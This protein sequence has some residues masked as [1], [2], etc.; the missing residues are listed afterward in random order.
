MAKNDINTVTIVGRLT[1]HADLRFTSGGMA[2]SEF[3]VAVNYMTK[4]KDAWEESVNFF[5]VSSFG[6]MA[7]AL[8]PYLTKGQQVAVMGELRQHQWEKDGKHYSRVYILARQINLLGGT[9]PQAS[10]TNQA[11]Q[12]QQEVQQTRQTTQQDYKQSQ[13]QQPAQ[14]NLSGMPGPEAFDNMEDIPF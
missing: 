4:K 14:N 8:Q 6:K 1:K 10:Q 13:Q 9:K 5:N 7:E 3:S 11:N 2:I 12:H